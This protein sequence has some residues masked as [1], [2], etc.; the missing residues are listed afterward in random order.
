M[1]DGAEQVAITFNDLDDETKEDIE[2]GLI[3][4]EDAIKALGGSMT[5]ERVAEYRIKA[6]AKGMNKSEATVYT[7]YDLHR[8]P[9][10]EEVEEDIDLFAGDDDDDI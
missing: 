7:E 5:G 10:I 8:L 4:E 9:V 3:S 2:N 1:I 6:L